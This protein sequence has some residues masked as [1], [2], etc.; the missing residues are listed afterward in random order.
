MCI[1][2]Y[3]ANLKAST[4]EIHRTYCT[5]ARY[6]C[7]MLDGVLITTVVYDFIIELIMSLG[8]DDMI[9]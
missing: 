5:A 7:C 3:C 1:C 4:S 9:R 6:L 2:L 8:E